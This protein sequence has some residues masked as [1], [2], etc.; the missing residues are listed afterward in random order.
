MHV[1]GV[2]NWGCHHE[3]CWLQG[4]WLLGAGG[5][6]A[7]ASVLGMGMQDE[8]CS[9]LRQRDGHN[10]LVIQ[11]GSLCGAHCGGCRRQKGAQGQIADS[12][13]H[14]VLCRAVPLVV[15]AAELKMLLSSVLPGIGSVWRGGA[16]RHCLLACVRL[17]GGGVHRRLPLRVLA[18]SS[19]HGW[20][21]RL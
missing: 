13:C 15:R 14:S 2:T 12:P 16:A 6:L 19:R 11:T 17:A 3:P 20:R 5:S 9:L 18:D 8:H 1:G 4:D 10:E 21:C 7:G